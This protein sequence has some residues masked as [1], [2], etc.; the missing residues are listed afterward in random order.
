[1][2][3]RNEK[4]PCTWNA[5]GQKKRNSNR[6]TRT[7]SADNGTP[8]ENLSQ[9]KA[10]LPYRRAEQQLS[11]REWTVPLQGLSRPPKALASWMPAAA[12][13]RVRNYASPEAT[14]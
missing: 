9:D 8:A 13:R 5:S 7:A 1:M 3:T 12:M 4:N 14:I 10:P 6:G 11:D 2:S